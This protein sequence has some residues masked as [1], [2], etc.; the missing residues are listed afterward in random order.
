MDYIVAVDQGT[1]SSRCVVFDRDA[2]VVAIAQE[3]IKRYFPH[4]GWVE[5]DA[6]E[7]WSSQLG[8]YFKALAE[9][10]LSNDDVAAIGVTNQRETTVVWDRHTGK[11]VCL[12]PVWQCRRGA[13]LIEKLVEEGYGEM[14]REKT[15]LIP[16]AYFSASKLAWILDNVEG[17]RE[18]A[19]VGDILFGTVDSWLIWNMT[20][21]ATHA[22]DYTNASRT[23]LFNIKTLEWDKELLDLFNIPPQMLPEV[24]STFEVFGVTEGNT[25]S[26]IP[27]CGVLGDQQ[28]ALFAQCCFEEGDTKATYGTGSFV[29]MNTGKKL[30]TS[31]HG[32]LTTIAFA[33]TPE[34]SDE[35]FVTYALEGSVYSAGSTVQWLRDGLHLIREAE[36]A[37]AIAQS[38]ESADGVYLVPAFNGLGAPYWDNEARGVLS[39]FTQ[40]TTQAHIVRAALESIAFQ[41]TDVIEAM[42]K[43]A[44]VDI[45]ELRVDGGVSRNDFVMQF[46][47]DLLDVDVVRPEITEATA[48]GAAL[49]AGIATGF[50]DDHKE[51]YDIIG[52][53]STTFIPSHDAEK[54][55]ELKAG[56][57]H[58]IKQ[59]QV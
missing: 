36:N 9:A 5:Q 2:N 29:L 10:G 19:E 21:G 51:F 49:C 44:E 26:Q 18:G 25:K 48:L 58:A 30:V 57:A 14:I 22:T 55:G 50:W 40:G 15:G 27:I 1:T 35:L 42:A 17:V 24:K 3:E 11:P 41:V 39:G 38:V 43:D 4:S 56:W 46:Q 47:A 16:D 6:T 8:M 32:L 13:P 33:W 7:I 37:Q 52:R 54:V 59:A 12:A 20:D 45:R 28:S 34:G 23:L 53:N 31:N